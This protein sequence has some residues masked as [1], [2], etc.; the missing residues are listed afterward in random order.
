MLAL[1]QLCYEDV[2]PDRFHRDLAE[3]EHVILLLDRATGELV[4]FSTI[5]ARP[6]RVGGDA[7]DIV[8][9]GDT[10]LHPDY[11][12][13]T[14]LD[15]AFARFLLARKLRHPLRSLRWLL[16]SGG[17]KTYLKIIN[18]FPIT[19]PRRDRQPAAGELAF[20]DEVCR[21]WFGDQFDARR[22]VLRLSGHYRVRQ[23][24]APIDREVARHPDI[25]FFAERNPGHVDGEE[26][27]CMAEVRLHDLL[28]TAVRIAGKRVRRLWAGGERMASGPEMA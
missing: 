3:K 8:F 2:D 1:M 20:R 27:V 26:L 16:L 14:A 24:L 10:V 15:G 7:A 17:Y 6:E 12:G 25:A 23:G 13:Q 9:S 5:R 4:G 11:W 28:R 21:R 18:Y 22:G 19:S